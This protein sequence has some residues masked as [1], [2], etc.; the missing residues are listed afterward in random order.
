MYGAT[1][2]FTSLG[3]VHHAL[4]PACTHT[5][6]HTQPTTIRHAAKPNMH[7]HPPPPTPVHHVPISSTT[8]KIWAS[9]LSLSRL[10]VQS[11]TYT[12]TGTHA[13]TN[14]SHLPTCTKLTLHSQ[15][16]DYTHT[17]PTVLVLVA[18]EH[19]LCLQLSGNQHRAGGGHQI[20]LVAQHIIYQWKEWQVIR[21][22]SLASPDSLEEQ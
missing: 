4:S 17:E 19:Q 11:I 12:H 22:Q 21:S 5:H 13:C 6:V 10:T 18:P 14:P 20:P 16:N 9:P 3:M 8:P 7:S 1:Y 2:H 15:K